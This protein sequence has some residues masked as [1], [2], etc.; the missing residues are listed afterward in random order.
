M[1]RGRGQAAH[2]RSEQV[3]EAALGLAD[4]EG[5][6]AVSLRRLARELGVT[7]M[8]LYH[9]VADKQ[10]L[11]DGLLEHLLRRHDPVGHDTHGVGD[12]LVETFGRIRRALA[13]H[14]SLT[15]LV[16]GWIA[17]GPGE[18]SMALT[19]EVLLRLRSAGLG[20]E[21]AAGLLYDLLGYTLGYA[22]LEA[23]TRVHRE[24]LVGEEAIAR[25]AARLA[26]AAPVVAEHAVALATCWTAERYE[27]GVWRIV[28]GAGVVD[29]PVA[30]S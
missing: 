29:P 19:A 14:P 24:G 16:R 21:E 10:A 15:E 4:R 3:F 28:D 25:Y 6:E 12:W 17:A 22:Q 5:L 23:A 1:A 20:A 7:P 13:L 11:L 9:H 2:L 8:A 18:T 30:R 27:R 26:E